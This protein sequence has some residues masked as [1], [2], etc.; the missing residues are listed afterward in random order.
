ML[1][2]CRLFYNSKCRKKF[3]M[4]GFNNRRNTNLA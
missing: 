2:A 3:A 4:L 1:I